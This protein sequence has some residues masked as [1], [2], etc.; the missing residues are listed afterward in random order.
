MKQRGSL[1]VFLKHSARRLSLAAGLLLAAIPAHSARIASLNLCTDQLALLLAD[2]ADIIGVS[3]LARDCTESALCE[4]ARHVPVIQSTAETVLAAKPD[5][6]LAGTF[7]ARLAVRA[8]RENGATVLALPPPSGLDDIPRQIRKVSAAVGHPERGEVLIDD[9]EKRLKALSLNR[10]DSNP[11]AVV[12]E[13][14]G[15]VV[16][17]GSLVDDVLAHA[18]LR[19]FSTIAGTPPTGGRVRLEV[20]LAYHPDLLIRDFSGPGRSL[21]QA[22]LSS[23]ALTAAFPPPHVTDVPASLWLC[24]LPQTLDA[25]A[26]LRQARDRLLRKDPMP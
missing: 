14:N 15:F 10:T 24:G 2:K 21:A 25:L 7:T 26:S 20:L 22:M 4:E 9:F 16:H 5:V 12:Y 1:S 17:K 23:P 18:G 8:A 3:S 11:V 19:N 6:V 13:A